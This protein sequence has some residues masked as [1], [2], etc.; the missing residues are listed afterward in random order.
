MMSEEIII[1]WMIIMIFWL[2]QTT[3]ILKEVTYYPHR[4]P[5]RGCLS[6]KSRLGILITKKGEFPSLEAFKRLTLER[7]SPTS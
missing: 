1:I 2:V 6:L 4:L 5:K 3:V 7:W